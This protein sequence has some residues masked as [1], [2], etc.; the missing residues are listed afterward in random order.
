MRADVVRGRRSA[1]RSAHRRHAL[2]GAVVVACVIAS[3]ARAGDVAKTPVE[4]VAL[5]P[6]RVSPREAPAASTAPEVAAANEALEPDD[7]AV[8][9]RDRASRDVRT[10]ASREALL[11]EQTASARASARWRLR[12]LTRLAFADVDLPPVARARAMDAI[13]RAVARDLAEA[14]ALG[15]ERTRTAND[16]ASLAAAAEREPEI[17]APP[18]LAPP[19]TGPVLARFGVSQDRATGLLV[20]RAGVRLAAIAGQGVRAPAAGVVVAVRPDA[21]GAAVVLDH[22]AGWTSIVGGLAADVVVAAGDH[23]V[24]GQRL[25]VAAT[26]PAAAV[27]LEVWRGLHPVDPTLLVRAAAAPLAAPAPL[28]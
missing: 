22:G 23:V 3:A 21:Q 24:A 4:P 18:T 14:R 7:D 2:A 16:R 15:D 27:E 9:E 11:G 19:V 5:D 6:S 26:G 20:S 10:L 25:G 12:A 1:R 28:P 13:A 8:A 17:G